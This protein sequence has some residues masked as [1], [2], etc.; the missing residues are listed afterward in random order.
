[1][2]AGLRF[3]IYRDDELVGTARYAEDAAI[4]VGTGGGGVIRHGSKHVVWR[5][6]AEDFEAAESYDRAAALMNLRI[7]AFAS[8]P[9]RPG[10]RT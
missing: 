7:E 10:R 3:L 1:M 2:T 6:G 5:D 8:R 9:Q 4:I